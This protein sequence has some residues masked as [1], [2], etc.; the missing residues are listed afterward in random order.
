MYLH[1]LVSVQYSI[2]TC[3]FQQSYHYFGIKI[4]VYQLTKIEHLLFP[5]NILLSLVLF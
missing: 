5:Q 3:N 4:I 2:T 1:F